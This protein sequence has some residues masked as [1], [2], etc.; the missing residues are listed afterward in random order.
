[1]MICK[2][3]NGCGLCEG[4][5]SVKKDFHPIVEN[6]KQAVF[7]GDSTCA[8]N[9]AGIAVDVGTTTIAACLFRLKDGLKVFETG[10]KNEQSL[11]GSDVMARITA[12]EKDYDKVRNVLINQIKNIFNYLISN[13]AVKFLSLRSGRL[14]LKRVVFTGNTTML[15]FIAG[16][17]VS[18]LKDFPFEIP[19]SFD[20]TCALDEIF[21]LSAFTQHCEVYFPP[22]ISAFVGADTVC[23]MISSF[24]ESDESE[25]LADTGTNCEMAVYDKKNNKIYCTSSSAGPAFEGCGIRC[26]MVCSE[27][28]IACVKYEKENFLCSV[29][30]GKKPLGICGTGLLSA[31]K[32]FYEHDFIDENG[33]IENENKICLLENIFVSQNDIRNFQ[34]AKAAVFTGLDFLNEKI[35]SLDNKVLYLC[36]GFG[37]HINLQDAFYTGMIPSFFKD[38]VFYKGNAALQGAA[39]MLFDFSFRKKGKKFSE[40]A[41]VINLAEEKTFQDRYISALNFPSKIIYP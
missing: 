6:M 35:N 38:K 5:S 1:M 15:S 37:S 13:A 20:Y 22:V 2:R 12:A 28:A 31:V 10:E 23:A 40:I 41:Q 9:E 4:D 7:K 25:F 33:I 21:D 27:G 34:L 39:L 26:G 19:S 30:G 8:L 16:K 14:V 3:C 24:T 18:S 29:V 11:F 17:K 32:T 36:G